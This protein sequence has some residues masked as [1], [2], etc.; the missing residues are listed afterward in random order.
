MLSWLRIFV[1]FSSPTIPTERRG[2]EVVIPSDIEAKEQ[3]NV[4]NKRMVD[5]C[6]AGSTLALMELR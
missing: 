1:I 5:V 3:V 6:S 2:E 4:T